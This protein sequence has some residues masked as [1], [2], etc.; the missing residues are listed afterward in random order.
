MQYCIQ[1]ACGTRLFVAGEHVRE[2]ALEIEALD[3]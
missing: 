2:L 1:W 3:A